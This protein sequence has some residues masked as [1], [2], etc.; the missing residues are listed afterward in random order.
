MDEA[1]I[2]YKEAM[3]THRWGRK[4]YRPDV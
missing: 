4:T 3:N 1:E 2:Y